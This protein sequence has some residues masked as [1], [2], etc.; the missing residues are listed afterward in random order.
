M[1]LLGKCDKIV[2]IACDDSE[3]DFW[4]QGSGMVNMKKFNG[5][6][7]Y[8]YLPSHC[9]WNNCSFVISRHRPVSGLNHMCPNVITTVSTSKRLAA[10]LTVL[11]TEF[12]LHKTQTWITCS[13]ICILYYLPWMETL[14]LPKLKDHHVPVRPP[15]FC[16][17]EST[18]EVD[19]LSH[20]C[21]RRGH[22]LAPEEMVWLQAGASKPFLQ[23]VRHKIFLA[24]VGLSLS[25]TQLHHLQSH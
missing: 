5:V 4:L 15:W 8:C 17:S 6:Q 23:R 25:V 16:S 13:F 24:V 3:L 11:V 14:M 21:Q 20:L 18:G 9:R 19:S 7:G 2:V 10:S 1:V 22:R 12:T